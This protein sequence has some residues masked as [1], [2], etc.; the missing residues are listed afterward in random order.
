MNDSLRYW[1]EVASEEAY[2]AYEAA[3]VAELCAKAGGHPESAPALERT[4]LTVAGIDP[5]RQRN[6]SQQ[7]LFAA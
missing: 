7:E 4:L 1:H 6:D 3:R 2:I 5:P